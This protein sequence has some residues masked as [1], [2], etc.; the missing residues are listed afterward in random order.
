MQCIIHSICD[1][2]YLDLTDAR[3]IL[4]I[5]LL[6]NNCR[7]EAQSLQVEHYFPNLI[8]VHQVKQQLKSLSR[9]QSVY[10]DVSEYDTVKVKSDRS[11]TTDNLSDNKDHTRFRLRSGT[12]I[13]DSVNAARYRL[14]L[15][16]KHSSGHDPSV[17]ELLQEDG[18]T[19]VARFP[20]TISMDKIDSAYNEK[21]LLDDLADILPIELLLP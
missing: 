19:T 2:A 4:E 17:I 20:S 8:A 15:R 14:N 13:S 18:D 12:D 21:F 3:D 5:S 7:Y 6:F 10:F 16:K 9:K 1:S 11:E